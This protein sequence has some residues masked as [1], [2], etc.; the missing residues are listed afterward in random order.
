[1]PPLI[2]GRSVSVPIDFIRGA[3]MYPHTRGCVWL[4]NVSEILQFL[5]LYA[6]VRLTS[7]LQVQRHPYFFLNEDTY[8]LK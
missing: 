6:I 3:I 1:M 2:P 8:E 5:L 4:I 7:A